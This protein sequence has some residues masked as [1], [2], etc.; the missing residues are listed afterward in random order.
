MA[1]GRSNATPLL[2]AAEVAELM[3]AWKSIIGSGVADPFKDILGADVEIVE[4]GYG[5]HRHRHH[6]H[7]HHRYGQFGPQYPGDAGYQPQVVVE[8]RRWAGGNGRRREWVR[9]D[10]MGPAAGTMMDPSAWGP[11]PEAPPAPY[12]FAPRN[13]LI[14]RPGPTRA[15]RVILPMSSG[16]DIGVNT[17]AQ[18]TSR[19]QDVAFRPER[20]IIGAAGTANGAADWVVNDIKVGNRS[21]FSQSGD[22]PGDMFAST[23]IDS[24]VSFATVQTAMDFVMLVTY[25]G[26]NESLKAPFYCSVLG[27]AAV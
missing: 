17:S 16:V 26:L 2:G 4:P 22:V 12:A 27:T 10:D 23:T 21:Q 24:Y 15:D 20:V 8:R 9:G 5:G 1:Y 7:H 14:D 3:G 18:I 13:E 19:P 11:E 6:R 25:V